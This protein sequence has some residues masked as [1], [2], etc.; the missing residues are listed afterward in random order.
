MRIYAVADL[1][2][3]VTRLELIRKNVERY[4][5]DA[6]VMAGD[7]THFR[8][9]DQFLE[10]VAELPIPVLAVRG[11]TDRVDVERFFEK[12]HNIIPLHLSEFL[13]KKVR[14]TGVSGTVLLPFQS[15]LSLWE[16]RVITQVQELVDDKT[17]LVA[18][19]PPWKVLDRAKGLF[20]VGSPGV[21]KVILCRCPALFLCGHVHESPG[22]MHLGPTL[23]VNCALNVWS[24][25]AIVDFVE[26]KPVV[27]MLDIKRER[28][29]GATRHETM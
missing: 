24:Q 21:R 28:E 16:G 22:T 5:P 12:H 6:V 1:H 14:F 23:V 15:K 27:T 3:D 9:S 4:R 10:K 11:N 18:H 20:H 2:G 19:P 26:E 17:V 13:I 8:K 7:I 25:G 29:N